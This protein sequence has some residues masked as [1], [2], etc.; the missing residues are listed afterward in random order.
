MFY[1]LIIVFALWNSEILHDWC[2]MEEHIS[3]YGLQV[4]I[5]SNLG[6]SHFNSGCH[7]QF[8]ACQQCKVVKGNVVPT[9]FWALLK[10]ELNMAAQL[11]V[12]CQTQD[13][14]I[15]RIGSQALRRTLLK[16]MSIMIRKIQKKKKKL[17]TDPL[18]FTWCGMWKLGNEPLRKGKNG[19]VGNKRS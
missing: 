10:L 19:L 7:G 17:A 2:H 6:C 18:I 8:G 3:F 15:D 13:V 14:A 5:Q 16:Q 4:S 12:H 9:H 1:T 11:S